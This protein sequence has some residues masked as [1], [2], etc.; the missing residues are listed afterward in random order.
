MLEDKLLALLPTLDWVGGDKGMQYARYEGGV[1]SHSWLGS[2]YEYG[3]DIFKLPK[4]VDDMLRDKFYSERLINLA[5]GRLKGVL[6]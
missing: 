5:E 1:F 2:Y 3:C 4:V 6:L